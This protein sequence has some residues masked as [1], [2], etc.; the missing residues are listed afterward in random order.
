MPC[1]AARPRIAQIR[2]CPPPPP[3]S[4]QLQ[5]FCF[6]RRCNVCCIPVFKIN[7]RIW[8]DAYYAY[9]LVR[10]VLKLSELHCNEPGIRG[11][12]AFFEFRSCRYGGAR[13]KATIAAFVQK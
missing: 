5:K 7:V 11:T 1:P 8:A 4:A 3:G 2:E 13:H 10:M 6:W 9:N 12:S